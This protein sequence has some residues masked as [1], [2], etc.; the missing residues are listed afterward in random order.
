M[1]LKRAFKLRARVLEGAILGNQKRARDSGV[2]ILDSAELDV[3][4]RDID[5]A[6]CESAV[7]RSG[8]SQTLRK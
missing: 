4:R 1:T 7:A 5:F 6:F 8:L 2:E 3:W